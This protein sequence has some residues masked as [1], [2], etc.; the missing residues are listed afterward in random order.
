[1]VTVGACIASAKGGHLAV[2]QRERASGISWESYTCSEAA[3]GE[4]LTVVMN[5]GFELT[6]AAGMLRQKYG[7]GQV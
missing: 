7:G 5:S 6:T 2:V 3:M 4:H 1:M